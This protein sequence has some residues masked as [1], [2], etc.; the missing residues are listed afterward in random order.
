MISNTGLHLTLP[1]WHFLSFLSVSQSLLQQLN[2][3]LFSE[4]PA[5]Y[6]VVAVKAYLNVQMVLVPENWSHFSQNISTSFLRACVP[7]FLAW[8][9]WR[10]RQD[11]HCWLGGWDLDSMWL[12]SVKPARRGRWILT[13]AEVATGRVDE[14]EWIADWQLSSITCLTSQ[15][16]VDRKVDVG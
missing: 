1:V 6:S 7:S 3:N 13:E 11:S 10:E 4:V 9:L 14:V 12:Y 8:G 5:P 2:H 15:M 16:Q